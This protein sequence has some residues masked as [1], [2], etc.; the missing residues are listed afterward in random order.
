[1]SGVGFSLADGVD[2]LGIDLRRLWLGYFGL[3]GMCDVDAM[4]LNIE[5]GDCDAHEYNRIA[6]ALNEAFVARGHQNA[7]VGYRP[8]RRRPGCISKK[9]KRAV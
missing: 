9:L 7:P 1:M 6:L 5:T 8:T 4:R 3:G 2:L